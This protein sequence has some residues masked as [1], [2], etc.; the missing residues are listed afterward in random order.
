[1]LAFTATPGEGVSSLQRG[2]EI[3]VTLGG[4]DAVA[5][6][7]L[8][9]V[10]I[11]ELVGREKS[12]VSRALKTLA[13]SGFVERDPDTLT[14]R[15]GRT[16]FALGAQADDARLLDLARPVLDGLLERTQETAHLSVLDGTEVVT[17]LSKAPDSAVRAAGWAGRR[18]P[19]ACTSSGR[20][21]L[22]DHDADELRR[23]FAGVELPS[24]GP[25]A[26]RSLDDLVARIARD[27]VGG[28][29]VS[30]EEFEAG[31]VAVAAPVRGPRGDIVAVVNVSAPEFRLGS[32]LQATGQHVRR[33][34]SE[35][36][37]ALGYHDP[38][39]ATHREQQS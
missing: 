9:V 22:F 34:A 15:L 18:V 16:M 20:A 23:R 28:V 3:L 27:S 10:R 12:Q 26:P 7:G 38:E 6:G 21:L 37:A 11:A 33:A 17:L 31:L 8:G 13:G 19:A 32:E 2:L 14:Y 36:S 5:R 30:I 1:M 39:L 4:R 29:A 24:G 25:N 35:L